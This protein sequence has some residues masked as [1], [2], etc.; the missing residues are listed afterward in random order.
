MQYRHS[1]TKKHLVLRRV[2]DIKLLGI[3]SSLSRPRGKKYYP[4]LQFSPSEAR[5]AGGH[6]GVQQREERANS[7]PLPFVLDWASVTAWVGRH[8]D[9]HVL[10][11]DFLPG[12]KSVY[13]MIELKLLNIQLNYGFSWLLQ[14][15][16]GIYLQHCCS[17]KIL[18]STYKFCG[19]KPGTKKK[20]KEKKK[21]KGQ[22]KLSAIL[23][24][25]DKDSVLE[26]LYSP[27]DQNQNQ[28]IDIDI[29]KIQNS[30]SPQGPVLPV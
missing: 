13:P 1:P 10:T 8:S 22:N 26:R 21:H 19:K 27:K 2:L 14:S 15:G 6:D 30:S 23:W 12:L 16:L 24:Q 18:K 11:T 4:T 29:V 28:D 25:S 3:K 20:P 17:G 5:E 7:V 9:Q